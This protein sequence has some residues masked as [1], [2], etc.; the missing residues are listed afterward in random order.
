MLAD[1]PDD[2][3][4]P[5]NPFTVDDLMRLPDDGRRYELIDGSLL[6]SPAPIPIHQLI[7][8]RLLVVLDQVVPSEYEALDTLNVKVDEEN[9]FIPDLVVVRTES[10]YADKLMLDPAEVL[11]AAE[12]VSPSTRSRD[13]ILK[14]AKYAEA[15][16]SY[17]WRV[18]PK[19]GPALYTYE[20]GEDRSYRL[21]HA[22]QAG[23]K[24]ELTRPFPVTLDPADWTRRRG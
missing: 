5:R 7:V 24:I 10:V 1:S 19:E 15:G 3:T 13:R 20:L 11:L 17:Y 21:C 18:E 22:V 4:D 9:F 2:A 16:I 14:L 12:I 23:E 8:K 6:V